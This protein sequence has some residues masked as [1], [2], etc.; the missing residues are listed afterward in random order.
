MS[1]QFNS[2]VKYVDARPRR[3]KKL[4]KGG[5][6][7]IVGGGGSAVGGGVSKSYVD[8]TFVTLATGQTIQGRKNFVGGV[9]VNGQELV[10]DAE[11]KVWQLVGDLLVTGAITMF[12]SLSG[13]QPST[14]TE[15]VEVDGE[16]IVK[17]KNS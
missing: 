1:K 11:K 15:A 14:V 16:T 13:F 3:E 17:T 12:G 2:I 8:S 7:V 9:E 5:S 6:T 10:Y 4:G